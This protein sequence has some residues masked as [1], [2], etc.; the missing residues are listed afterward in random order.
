MKGVK[1]PSPAQ[2]SSYHTILWEQCHAF[3]SP[4]WEGSLYLG[5]QGWRG[6]ERWAIRT[7]LR[8][9]H[10]VLSVAYSGESGQIFKAQG[11]RSLTHSPETAPADSVSLS[12]LSGP[13]FSMKEKE[14]RN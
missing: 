11:R 3:Q 8:Q 7:G 5:E 13:N 9:D 14:K 1:K 12:L 10:R 6:N 2:L 4:G